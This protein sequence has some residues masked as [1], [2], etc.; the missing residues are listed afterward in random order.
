MQRERFLCIITSLCS[1]RK[2]K[3]KLNWKV[4][5]KSGT[6]FGLFQT[7]QIL[8]INIVFQF[9]QHF[10]PWKIQFPSCS[11]CAELLS[12]RCPLIFR[13]GSSSWI[14]GV[15][16]SSSKDLPPVVVNQWWLLAGR[17]FASNLLTGWQLPGSILWL[18]FLSLQTGLISVHCPGA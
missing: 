14:E 15:S 6:S 7:L 13:R 1:D 10:W 16:N 2:T 11:E 5:L 3:T 4:Q 12:G 8:N 9:Q 17:L 18:L